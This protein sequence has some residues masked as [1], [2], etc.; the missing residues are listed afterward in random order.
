MNGGAAKVKGVELAY[1]QQFTFLPGWLKGFGVFANYTR[2]EAEGDYGTGRVGSTNTLAGFIPEVGNL[3]ISYIRQPL[4][5][6]FQF[7]HVG[8]YLSSYNANSAL[9]RY[10]LQR[11]QLDIKSAWWINRHYSFY[12]DVYNVFVEAERGDRWFGGLPRNVRKEKGPLFVFGIK[13]SY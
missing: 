13:G 11:D 9:L 2:L 10:Q 7:N 12:L 8:S 5:L 1:Q 3:G 6:R 4:T